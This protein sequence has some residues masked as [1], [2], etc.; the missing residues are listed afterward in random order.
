MAGWEGEDL[1]PTGTMLKQNVVNMGKNYER[2][3]LTVWGDQDIKCAIC[4]K[5][6]PHGVGVEG[7]KVDV[8]VC[9]DCAGH[10][11]ML[12][13]EANDKARAHIEQG[14]TLHAKIEG[15]RK[16]AGGKR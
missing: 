8:D 2:Y 11:I 3:S 10:Q 6:K 12:G 4:H 1:S 13:V 16:K 14:K 5:M 7:A 15:I 9:D